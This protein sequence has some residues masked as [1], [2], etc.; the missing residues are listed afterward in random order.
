MFAAH[1]LWLERGR[2]RHDLL[3]RAVITGAPLAVF[4]LLR[5]QQRQGMHDLLSNRH[6][7]WI[8]ADWNA[9]AQLPTLLFLI[10]TALLGWQSWRQPRPLHTAM[11]LAFMCL[12]WMLPRIFLQ[13]ALLP[14]LSVAALLL[15]LAAM[16]QESFDMAFRDELTCFPGRRAFN[17]Y[18]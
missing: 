3:L 14:T 5:S 15:L 18:Q 11:L 6:W 16:L 13:P 2:R 7:Q 9:L 10:S 12:W 17:T 8:P 1:A 4:L